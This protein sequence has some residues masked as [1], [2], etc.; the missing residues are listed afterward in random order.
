M[1]K[2]LAGPYAHLGVRFIPTGGVNGTNLTSY[3]VLD[4]VAAV[5]GTWIATKV[6]LAGGKW[7]EIRDRCKRAVEIVAQ[8]RGERS[9]EVLG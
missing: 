1:L 6:D 3:L 7:S 4:A 9:R 8:V 2:A 5:G